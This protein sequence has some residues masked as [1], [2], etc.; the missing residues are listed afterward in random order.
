M[1]RFNKKGLKILMEEATNIDKC[2]LIEDN[3]AI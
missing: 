3:R 2:S 1:I